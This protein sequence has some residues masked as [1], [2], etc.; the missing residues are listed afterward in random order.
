MSK[1]ELWQG[2][3]L[4]LM[5]N[6]KWL[7]FLKLFGNN[8]TLWNRVFYQFRQKM[9]LLLGHLGI[10]YLILCLDLRVYEVKILLRLFPLGNCY[11]EVL[12]MD[13][14]G[15]VQTRVAFGRCCY[16]FK[17]NTVKAVDFARKSYVQRVVGCVGIQFKTSDFH[18]VDAIA[19]HINRVSKYFY[20]KGKIIGYI[21]MNVQF[22]DGNGIDVFVAPT[23]N[24][25]QK[26]KP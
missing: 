18:I 8:Q 5:K 2:N 7:L 26:R 14:F 9:W 10:A 12:E 4:E 6:I 23:G 24:Q 15:R 22:F 13:K 19:I 11:F 21:C 17:V 16:C 1:I 20:I 25:S 3:C